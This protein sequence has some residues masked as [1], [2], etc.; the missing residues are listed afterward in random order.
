MP[1]RR[2]VL[3]RLAAA[4]VVVASVGAIAAVAPAYASARLHLYLVKSEPS[5]G[6]TVATPK[7]VKLWFSE[8]ATI[9]VTTVR[10][11]GPDGKNVAIGKPTFTGDVKQPV[12]VAVTG[13]VSTGRYTVAYKTASGDMHP[14]TGEFTFVVR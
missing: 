1:S 13:A 14:V 9:A 12:E 7:A 6:D 3:R 2:S 5:K 11:T 10:L 8:A 4:L